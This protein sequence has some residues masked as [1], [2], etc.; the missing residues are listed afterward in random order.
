MKK[1]CS[2]LIALVLVLSLLTGVASA[3][4]SYNDIFTS[5][6]IFHINQIF[7]G[8]DRYAYAGVTEDGIVD[9]IEYGVKGDTIC[10]WVETMYFPLAGVTNEEYATMQ[11]RLHSIYDPLNA[12]LFTS[13]EYEY[14]TTYYK[15]TLR[16]S[17][18]DNVNHVHCLAELGMTDPSIDVISL[19]LT[20]AGLLSMGYLKDPASSY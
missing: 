15:M 18:L 12:Y 8:M 4:Y 7:V 9:C 14:L 19:S 3:Q 2:G 10:E 6:Y 5:N 20:E 13:V 17:E 11:D 1:F 16:I